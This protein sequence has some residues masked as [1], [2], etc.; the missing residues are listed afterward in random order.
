[1][2]DRS[3][4][5]AASTLLCMQQSGLSP[6]ANESTGEF[7]QQRA[8]PPRC[9]HHPKPCLQTHTFLKS[10]YMGRKNTEEPHKGRC[11]NCPDPP[12]LWTPIPHTS[13]PALWYPRQ[14]AIPSGRFHSPRWLGLTSAAG[15]G[16]ANHRD[17]HPSLQAG[18]N[19]RC[20]QSWGKRHSR[21][22][23]EKMHSHA[24][25]LCMS[26]HLP[27]SDSGSI[28]AHRQGRACHPSVHRLS[29]DARSACEAQRQ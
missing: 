16:S 26:P 27:G 3:C 4:Y 19:R 23:R 15:R 2:R 29:T 11:V 25:R 6:A 13:S 5:P 10:I 28:P 18:Y 22:P 14:Q 17:P 9:Q 21:V 1:L 8:N 12:G 20:G 24:H 7:R